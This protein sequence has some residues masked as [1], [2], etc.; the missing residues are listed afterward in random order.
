M[1]NGLNYVEI[2]NEFRDD[3]FDGVTM[4]QIRVVEEIVGFEKMEKVI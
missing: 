4:G 1:T 2:A 3:S